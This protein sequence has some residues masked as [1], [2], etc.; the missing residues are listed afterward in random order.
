MTPVSKDRFGPWAVVTGASSGIGEEFARQLAASGLN[1]VL[2]ARRGSALEELGLALAQRYSIEYKTLAVDLSDEGSFE[3]IETSTR[4]LDV[5]LLV[6]NAGAGRPAEFL[7]LGEDEL[8]QSVRLNA[9]SH[10]RLAHHFGHRLARRG[11]GGI[12]LVSAMGAGD[13][14][15]Y[16]AADGAGKAFV[17]SL[18][19]ALHREFKKRGLN[20]TVLLPTVVETP[21]L[22]KLGF[23]AIKLPVKPFSVERCVDDGLSALVANRSSRLVGRL[24]R[25]IDAMV[26]ASIKTAM[27]GA[28]LAKVLAA[29]R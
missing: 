7:S 17:L 1:V 11:R 12:L 8:L 3:R 24:F 6:S 22:A 20:V 14:I 4:D 9:L 13:G 2:V 18:G 15:P 16:M 28:L 10:L 23:D 25:I 19:R 26:P 27:N 29:R 5:G 21:V